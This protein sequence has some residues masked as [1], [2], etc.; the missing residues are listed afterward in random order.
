MLWLNIDNNRF[1]LTKSKGY[2]L[3]AQETHCRTCHAWPFSLH[4]LPV[5]TGQTLTPVA[6]V[7]FICFLFSFFGLVVSSRTFAFE[8]SPWAFYSF[9]RFEF[10]S[11][12]K[13]R[14]HRAR[15]E[16]TENEANIAL[17]CKRMCTGHHQGLWTL[18][19]IGK[20][21][22]SGH[23]FQLCLS[24]CSVEEDKIRYDSKLT[25]EHIR[26]HILVRIHKYGTHC[27]HLGNLC[28]N[29]SPVLFIEMSSQSSSD[30]VIEICSPD[31]WLFPSWSSI[32]PDFVYTEM[33]V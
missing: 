18:H 9:Y 12:G 2:S 3:Q 1:E 6:L 27:A 14:R 5:A 8:F 11:T 30:I 32:S 10:Y 29:K 20:L 31:C 19:C 7:A 21:H 16:R 23:I 22:H 13:G 4:F 15:V 24:I 17:R 26:T 33:K 28:S 25:S